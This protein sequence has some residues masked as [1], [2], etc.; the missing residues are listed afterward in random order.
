MGTACAPFTH[1]KF[2][3][4]CGE[5]EEGECN[6]RDKPKV[7]NKDGSHLRRLI[8]MSAGLNQIFALDKITPLT[9]ESGRPLFK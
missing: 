2:S 7:E 8:I 6:G 5:K 3:N 1:A 4:V 9:K